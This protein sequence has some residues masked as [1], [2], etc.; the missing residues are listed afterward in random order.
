MEKPILLVV[1]DTL[2][3]FFSVIIIFLKS[4]FWKKTE[5]AIIF[6]HIP[7]RDIVSHSN[8]RFGKRRQ[9]ICLIGPRYLKLFSNA[10]IKLKIPDEGLSRLFNLR[11]RSVASIRFF[12]KKAFCVSVNAAFS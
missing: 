4:L 10:R 11:A 8:C 9:R 6:Q 2:G 12:H 5:D 1:F 7:A 3:R